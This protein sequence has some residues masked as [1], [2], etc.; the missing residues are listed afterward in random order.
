MSLWAPHLNHCYTDLNGK[1]NTS[2][3]QYSKI[4]PELSSVPCAR[5]GCP[6]GSARHLLPCQ[7]KK[8]P[9][10]KL[11]WWF[12][13]GSCARQL[14]RC[15]WHSPSSIIRQ[16]FFKGMEEIKAASSDVMGRNSGGGS[17]KDI[18]AQGEEGLISTATLE[19][20]CGSRTGAGGSPHSWRAPGGA[21]LTLHS[22]LTLLS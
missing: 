12:R 16:K 10:A 1:G 15:W 13:A 21:W 5:D 8:S 22:S 17:C 9:L 19:Q 20:R 14:W 11:M 4:L 3:L 18:H 6:C 7:G 2:M